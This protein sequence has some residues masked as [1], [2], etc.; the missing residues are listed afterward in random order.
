MKT[1]FPISLIFAGQVAAILRSEDNCNTIAALFSNTCGS[2]V[3][4]ADWAAATGT[5]LTCAGDNACVG[6]PTY[7][8]ADDLAPNPACLHTTK[9]C[10]TCDEDGDGQVWLTVQTNSMPQH[11][12]SVPIDSGLYPDY[13]DWEW[14]VH[15]NDN[16]YGDLNVAVSEIETIELA[17]ALLCDQD[18]TAVTNMSSERSF[19]FEDTYSDIPQAVGIT[20]KNQ[21]IFNP[22]TADDI[23]NNTVDDVEFYD[24]DYYDL[25][26]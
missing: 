1:S 7:V 25:C 26:L 14:K 18:I 9:T 17:D 12:Y 10:V 15:W 2:V 24:F 8:E 5:E 4:T 3:A 11:C 19:T 16:V 13:H 6:D 22:L 23:D 21:L 20:I